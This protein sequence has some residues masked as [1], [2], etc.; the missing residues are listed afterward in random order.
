MAVSTPLRYPGGKSVMT[1]FLEEFILVNNMQNVVYA[2]P[3]SGGA[4]AALNLLFQKSVDS[5]IIN[6]ASIPVYS[7][8]ESITN[9]S[10]RF[11]YFFENTPIT[12]PEWERQRDIFVTH[13]TKFSVEL[14]FATF[15]LNRCN[16]SGILKAGV[17]G[18]N[19]ME[20]Q[21]TAKYKIDARFNKDL[22]R[23]RLQKIIENRERIA[24]KNLDAL[25]FL[26]QCSNLSI[27][28]KQNLLIYLDPPYYIHGAELYMNSYQH[29]DHIALSNSLRDLD[30]IRWIL[31]YDNV[32]AIKQLYC[33]EYDLYTFDLKY[34]VQGAKTGKELLC[35]SQN[36]ILPFNLE[37]TRASGAIPLIPIL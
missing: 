12:I 1:P 4:G 22:L 27:D 26:E 9:F 29:E 37:I 17:I 19:S 8:W 2:E 28:E 5:I 35:H 34:T 6:D 36:S 13:N 14:G 7:F 24:I 30:I 25:V 16:R 15:F 33:D 3:Y 31:S 32:P 11:M 20:K 18:G 10:G 21:E 23:E